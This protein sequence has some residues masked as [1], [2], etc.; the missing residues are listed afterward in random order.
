MEEIIKNGLNGLLKYGGWGVCLVLIVIFL[1]NSQ[2]IMYIPE[3]FWGLFKRFWVFSFKKY[4]SSRLSNNIY[5]ATKHLSE[6]NG[7]ILPYRVKVKW[8]SE[9]SRKTFIKNGQIVVCINKDEDINKT[10]VLS[11]MDYIRRGLI[12]KAKLQMN[13]SA[14]KN[15]VDA[16]TTNH[17]LARGYNDGLYYFN[18]HILQKLFEESTEFKTL[19]SKLIEIDKSGLFVAVF[20]NEIGQASNSFSPGYS[21]PDFENEIIDLLE[22]LLKFAGDKWKKLR[23]NSKYFNFSFGL[24]ASDEHL[25]KFGEDDYKSKISE[26]IDE[27]ITSVYLNAWGKKIP[28]LKRITRNLPREDLRIEKV[29]YHHYFHVFDDG[30]KV[31]AVYAEIIVKQ[32]EN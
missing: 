19:Y 4:A 3:K 30:Q 12:S 6:S 7:A 1:F 2:N 25:N 28:V 13:N 24:L 10:F 18:N 16:C 17:I 20:L 31:D 14:L 8:V 15:A 9:E 27:G 26:S 11:T 21:V 32:N 5:I 23:Y 29:L 22:Y